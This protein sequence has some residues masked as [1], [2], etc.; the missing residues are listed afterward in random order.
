MAVRWVVWIIVSLAAPALPW[1]VAP[2]SGNEAGNIVVSLTNTALFLQLIA[3][4]FLSIGFCKKRFI[5]IGGAIGMSLVFML[6]SV[7]I[8]TAVW[9]SVCLTMVA[10]SN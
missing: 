5:S 9:F 7:A 3:S 4:I 6:A 1:L 8:G 10:T 2:L